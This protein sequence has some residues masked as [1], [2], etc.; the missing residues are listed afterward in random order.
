MTVAVPET[1]VVQSENGRSFEVQNDTEL[2]TSVILEDPAIRE[3]A[4]EL[5]SWA[6]NARAAVGRSSLFDRG[7]YA[8]PDNVYEQMKVA[9]RTTTSWA[10]SAT[11]PRA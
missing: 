4:N 3:I 8:S 10:A 9:Q 1:G 11:S 2:P 7:A 5:S 6:D